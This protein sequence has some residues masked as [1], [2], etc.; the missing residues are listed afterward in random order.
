M[1]ARISELAGPLARHT[2]DYYRRFNEL[3]HSHPHLS[4]GEIELFLLNRPAVDAPA[5][6]TP[7]EPPKDVAHRLWPHLK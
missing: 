3:T 6:P 4:R 2:R 5:K 7:A 1:T